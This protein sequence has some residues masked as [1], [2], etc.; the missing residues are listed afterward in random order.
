MPLPI[1]VE[2]ID[3]VADLKVDLHLGARKP[4]PHGG[5]SNESLKLALTFSDLRLLSSGNTGFFEDELLDLARQLPAGTS[6][7]SCLFCQYSDYSPYGSGLIG[8]MM[9]FRNIK[10]E[11]SRVN[12]K[13]AF[14]GV[15]DR[16]DR[17]VQETYLCDDFT[18]RIAG[19]GYR[20]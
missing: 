1:L 19:T 14:W 18:L 5:I 7:K 20:G 17:Q 10:A 12:S 9:C 2:G 11:Y 8:S 6:I 4:A 13:E 16:F 15:H 3:T